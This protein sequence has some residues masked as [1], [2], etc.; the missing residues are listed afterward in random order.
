[1]RK[2]K[3]IYLVFLL[4]VNMCFATSFSNNFNGSNNSVLL[5]NPNTSFSEMLNYSST[6]K[7]KSKLE[8]SKMYFNKSVKYITIAGGSYLLGGTA[9]Y[10]YWDQYRHDDHTRNAK[11]SASITAISFATG[12]IYTYRAYKQ[13]ILCLESNSITSKL[14]KKV[15]RSS[16]RVHLNSS[17]NPSN[18]RYSLNLQRNF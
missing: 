5:R 10:C 3:P 15:K 11:A 1:M 17:Y 6:N 13:F 12:I 4:L 16:K 14:S 8:K 9:I 18:Q 2:L 7:A